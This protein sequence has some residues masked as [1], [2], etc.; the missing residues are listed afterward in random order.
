E[1]LWLRTLDLLIPSARAS[2]LGQGGHCACFLWAELARILVPG[3]GDG[4]EV[5]VQPDDLRRVEVG[6]VGRDDGAPVTPLN[7]EML[8]TEI[9]HQLEVHLSDS[10]RVP[11]RL[12]RWS[13]EGIPRE[14]RRNDVECVRGRGSV[15]HWVAQGANDIEEFDDAAGPPM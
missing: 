9:R 13:R 12:G 7:A 5:E 14:G 10:A 8:I 1:C 11:S 2:P 4:D 3:S 6:H 15:T